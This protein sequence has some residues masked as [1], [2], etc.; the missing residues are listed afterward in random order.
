MEVLAAGV[1]V[2]MVAAAVGA[3]GCALLTRPWHPG[4]IVSAAIMLLAMTDMALRHILLV[5]MAWTAVLLALSVFVVALPRAADDLCDWH[6]GL[7]LVA[8]AMIMIGSPHGLPVA[9]ASGLGHG[10][11]VDS[12]VDLGSGWT[13]GLLT[14][15]AY[16][17]VAGTMVRR[18]SAAPTAGSGSRASRTQAAQVAS[19]AGCLALMS[20]LPVLA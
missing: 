10:G 14:A 9:N 19:T 16:A 6:H 4:A 13:L 1:W 18:E 3:F 20:L 11:H 15:A 12:A 8:A 7:A 17:L 5:P 2:A